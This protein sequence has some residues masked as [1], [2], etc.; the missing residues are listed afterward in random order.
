MLPFGLLGQAAAPFKSVYHMASFVGN[1]PAPIFDISDKFGASTN[2][3]ITNQEQG[4]ELA[5]SFKATGQRPATS[6][7]EPRNVVLMRGE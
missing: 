3:L 2:M 7:E 1:A 5:T 6:Q 4:D